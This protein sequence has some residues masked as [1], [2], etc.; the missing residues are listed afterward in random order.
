MVLMCLGMPVWSGQVGTVQANGIDIWYEEFGERSNPAVLLI[1][2]AGCQGIMWPTQFCEQLASWG[3]HVVR[4]DH[5]DMGES[6]SVDFEADPY[7]LAVLAEDAVGLLD[8]LAIERAHLFG[9][10]MGGPVAELV[11][12]AYPERVE[13]LTLVATSC[14]FEPGIRAFEGEPL[15]AG[16]LSP[17]WPRYVA[18]R[19]GCLAHPPQT[20]DEQVKAMLDGSRLLSG[21]PASFDEELYGQLHRQALSRQNPATFGNHLLAIKRSL[22]LVREAP[23]KVAAPTLIIHGSLDPVFPPDHGVALAGAIPHARLM[24]VEGMGHILNPAFYDLWIEAL[25]G[26]RPN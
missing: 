11:A 1:M 25:Q 9:Q 14:D 12:G 5:R 8:A 10:S 18:W 20:L 24:Q 21:D 19:N 17:P 7:D 26:L 22:D 13:S 15:E 16:M 23:V 6:S 4:Y 3:L 2:G